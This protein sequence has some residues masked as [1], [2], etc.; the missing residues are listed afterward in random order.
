[1]DFD[2]SARR[3]KQNNDEKMKMTTMMVVLGDQ[4]GDGH[5]M[6]EEFHV[7]VPDQY[8]QKTLQENFKQA[9]ETIGVNLN[10]FAAD[11]DDYRVSRDNFQP[12]FDAG[13]VFPKGTYDIEQYLEGEEYDHEYYIGLDRESFVF[14]LMFLY[15]YGLP[16]FTWHDVPKPPQLNEEMYAYGLYSH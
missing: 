4:Y 10:H 1:M 14:I 3:R 6:Y 9:V 2:Y 12:L 16:D 11:Y 5:G 13:L 15:G 8:T 7:N